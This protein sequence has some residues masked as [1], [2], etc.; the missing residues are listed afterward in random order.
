VDL[1]I[2]HLAVLSDGT[3]VEGPKSLRRR[4]KRLARVQ[5]AHARK[6]KGGKNRAK[7]RAGIA[8]LHARI[9][10][11]R[12]DALHKTTT[13]I[14]AGHSTIVIEDLNVRGMMANRRLALSIGDMG[15]FELRRQLTYKAERLGR[16]LILADRFYASS[17]ICSSCNTKAE[18]LPLSVRH[19]TC[20]HCGAQHDRDINAAINLKNLAGSKDQQIRP[21]TACGAEGAGAG[22]KPSV[23]PAA[24]K[25]ELAL[26]QVR[27]GP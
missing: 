11:I 10:N 22:L 16:Q 15:F 8:R 1:G 20:A 4:L 19:W 25:Q 23:K 9:R 26:D 27:S 5:R 3:K 12:Q 14:A 21:V 18:V 6:R 17:K 7:S 2:A 24:V 13:R